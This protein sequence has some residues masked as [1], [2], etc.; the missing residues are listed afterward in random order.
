MAKELQSPLLRQQ[1]LTSTSQQC[2]HQQQLCLRH[3]VQHLHSCLTMNFPS[4]QASSL[5]MMT[6]SCSFMMFLKAI[7]DLV[8]TSISHCLETHFSIIRRAN[9]RMKPIPKISFLPALHYV[10]LNKDPGSQMSLAPQ[11]YC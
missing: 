5:S 8:A 11:K 10:N 3:V 7:L 1:H 4:L 9:G 2:H 6:Q